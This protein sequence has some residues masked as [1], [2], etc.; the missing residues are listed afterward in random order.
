MPRLYP[1]AWCRASVRRARLSGAPPRG[2][3]RARPG[4]GCRRAHRP[5]RR[6]F[7]RRSSSAARRRGPHLGACG[8]EDL[9]VRVGTDHGPDV[10]AV[11]HGAGRRRREIALEIEQRRADL[12][13]GR[14]ERGRLAD[15]LALERR[16]VEA[17]RDRA[18]RPPPRRARDRRANGRRRATPSPPRGRSGRYRDAA[19]RN[20]RRAAC[21]ASPCPRPPARRWQ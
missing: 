10:A 20:A 5:R 7:P 21:R 11:E 17:R 9:H 3:Y 14:D 15:R 13:D 6:C 2:S 16:V 4:A 8:D 12:G 1:N 19:G 18:P